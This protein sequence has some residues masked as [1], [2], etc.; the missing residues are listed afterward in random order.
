MVGPP[1]DWA[2]VPDRAAGR[3]STRRSALPAGQFGRVV[4]TSRGDS[5]RVEFERAGQV[6]AV[7]ALDLTF[8]PAAADPR[9]LTTC[10]P[11]SEPFDT[12]PYQVF[13]IA[14]YWAKTTVDGVC[15]RA[16]RCS[17]RNYAALGYVASGWAPGVVGNAGSGLVL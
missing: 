17:S 8:E 5:L 9:L 14:V 4:A 12:S 15:D 6:V 11:M 2:A 16:V 3:R 13:L 10:Q 1:H 7:D